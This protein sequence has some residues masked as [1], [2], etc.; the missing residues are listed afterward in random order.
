[1]SGL[2]ARPLG[3][4]T[5]IGTG[6]LLSRKNPTPSTI[7]SE[8]TRADNKRLRHESKLH[9]RIVQAVHRANLWFFEIE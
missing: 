5:T 7:I 3:G 8:E 9:S 6:N 4:G 2:Q 1:M